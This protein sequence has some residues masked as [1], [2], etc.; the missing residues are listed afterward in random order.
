MSLGPLAK[1]SSSPDTATATASHPE[2]W[3]DG[4]T[5]WANL[6]LLCQVCALE[7]GSSYLDRMGSLSYNQTVRL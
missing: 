3:G 6:S 2:G 5:I 7:P 1:I 4:E